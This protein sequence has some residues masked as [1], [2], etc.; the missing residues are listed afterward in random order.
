MRHSSVA[1]GDSRVIRKSAVLAAI[2][3]PL[4]W[5]ASLG[6][7][8]KQ[9]VYAVSTS[10]RDIFFRKSGFTESSYVNIMSGKLT[11][12]ERCVEPSSECSVL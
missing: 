6:R 5:K 4:M 11:G 8:L 3:A 12:N 9:D 2:Q 1:V 7:S 10:I